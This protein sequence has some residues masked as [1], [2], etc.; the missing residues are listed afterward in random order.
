MQ[1]VALIVGAFWAL[2]VGLFLLHGYFLL[3]NRVPYVSLPD[4]A[5]PQVLK[6]LQLARGDVVYDLG[7]G[8]GRVLMA[9][10][11]VGGVSCVGIE[12]NFLLLGLARWRTRGAV[13]LVRR[14]VLDQDLSRA[15]RVVVYLGPELMRR[16]EPRFDQMLP[17]GARVVSVQF[18]LARRA[19]A[20]IELKG[21]ASYAAKAYVYQY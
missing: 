7:C 20:V 16:L 18:P 14:D 15:N 13:R 4:A 17:R 6:A 11:A 1:W 2:F 3:R 19:Q 9:V 8:D 10:K 12:N 21:S 5:I